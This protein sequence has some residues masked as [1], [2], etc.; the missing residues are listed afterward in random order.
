M[1]KYV[2]YENIDYILINGKKIEEVRADTT[3]DK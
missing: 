1:G 3:V 2:D